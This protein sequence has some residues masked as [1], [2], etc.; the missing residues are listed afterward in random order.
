MTSQQQFQIEPVG[1]IRSPYKEKFAVPR[2]PG[3]VPSAKAT[4]V[5]QGDANTPESVRGIEQFSHLWL[6]FLFDQNLSAG[7]RP[8]VRPPRLGGN[9]RIGVF[10]SRATFRP[11]GIGMSA[12]QLLGVRQAQGQILLDLAGVDLVDGTPVIDIKPYIPYSD[13]LPQATGGFA[14]ES[15]AL[16]PVEFTA[17]AHSQLS[18][19]EA[20][21]HKAVIT[22]VLAQDPRPAYKKG[23]PDD[24]EYGV[25]LF[26]YN[27]RFQF[28]ED[29]VVV[30]NLESA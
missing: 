6:L 30:K 11:N 26:D 16:L 22:E 8:T 19:Q 13:S 27:V 5:L 20:D 17:H 18:H 14:A 10:A 9:D 7:W 2:Q 15:P 12:I 24:K 3:L 21:Y 29:R 28:E 4:L 23:K 25:L 1:F